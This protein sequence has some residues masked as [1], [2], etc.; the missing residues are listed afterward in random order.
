MDNERQLRLA[1]LKSMDRASR[2]VFSSVEAIAAILGDEMPVLD[3]ITKEEQQLLDSISGWLGIVPY[4][5]EG[6]I[7]EAI[8]EKFC[9]KQTSNEGESNE[10]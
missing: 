5:I 8:A 9:D 7:R 3:E 6:R 10:S 1:A 4:M 2:L